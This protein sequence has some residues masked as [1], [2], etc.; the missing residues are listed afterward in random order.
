VKALSHF[1]GCLDQIDLMGTGTP[2]DSQFFA[3]Q[4]AGSLRSAS[5]IVPI[6]N[7][8]IAPRSV[9]DVGCG[10][11]TWLRTWSD[12]GVSQICGLD[13]DYVDESELMID[14]R[15]FIRHDLRRALPGIGTFDLA[16]SL[17]VAEHLPADRAESFVTDLTSLAPVVLF[18]AAIPKQG[19]T[20][21]INEQ[22]QDYWA[23]LFKARGFTAFDVVRPLIWNDE[24]V[25]RWYSQNA[26]LYCR[27]ELAQNYPALSI[28]RVLPL[29]LVHPKQYIERSNEYNVSES[30]ALLRHSLRRAG[31]QRLRKLVGWY[32]PGGG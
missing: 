4:R 24:R 15:F 1:W 13:G 2:Y 17:E 12:L 11:G 8:L 19:G 3:I 32:T 21:H 28:A 9:C 31:L 18:S 27:E 20:V 5:V 16:L 6:V 30:W 29:S 26:I 22:W 7:D 14:R 25:D 23:D 10:V